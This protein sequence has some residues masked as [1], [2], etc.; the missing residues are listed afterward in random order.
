M[1]LHPTGPYERIL[2]TGEWG[3]GKSKAWLKWAEWIQ[4]TGAS[5]RVFVI[6]T[7]TAWQRMGWGL[8]WDQPPNQ[9]VWVTDCENYDQA[10]NAVTSYRRAA[11]PQ[12]NDVLVIDMI[13]KLWDYAQAAFSEKAFG[14]N[15]TEWLL[16]VR[17]KGENPGGDYGVNWSTINRLYGDFINNVIRFPGHVVACSPVEDVKEPNRDGKGGDDPQIRQMFGRLKKKPRG[18]KN[19]PFQFHSILLM[20]DT[21]GAAVGPWKMTTMKERDVGAMA[22]EKMEGVDV[23]D[24]VLDYLIKRGGWKP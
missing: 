6:D 19:L 17:R 8:G 4:R 24:F 16:D 7:D 20:Q 23:K 5:S 21:S 3:S 18:Q 12:N 15:I 9:F 14:E 13:D 2:V 1:A 10:L 11:Q 22:R